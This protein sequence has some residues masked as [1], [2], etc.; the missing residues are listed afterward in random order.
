MSA[1]A[2]A[3]ARHASRLHPPVGSR[4][5]PRIA[6]TALDPADFRKPDP[7]H[8]A[9]SAR[10]S[11]QRGVVSA[12]ADGSPA[13]PATGGGSAGPR[14]AWRPCHGSPE[15]IWTSASCAWAATSSAGRRTSRRPSRCSTGTSTRR[16]STGRPFVDTAESYGDGTLG[17]DPRRLDG[18]ARQPRLGRRRHQGVAAEEG[19]PAGGAGRSGPRPSGRCATC[20]PTS[21]TSTTP[22]TTTRRR[23][24]RR[25]SPPSTSW[26][27][28]G[29]VRLRGRV[30]LL[31]EAADRGAGDLRPAGRRAVRRRCRRTTT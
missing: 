11:G 10:R 2:G 28:P 29:K 25:R 17:A 4:A 14:L 22:T 19:A 16:P 26:C 20:G 5:V 31:G 13:P 8:R 30:E 23:R 18:L 9:M 3:R 1:V 6:R 12:P 7:G 24:W 27:R 15:P 21:S